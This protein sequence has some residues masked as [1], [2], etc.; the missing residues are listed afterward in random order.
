MMN[1]DG[2]GIGRVVVGDVLGLLICWKRRKEKKHAGDIG[3]CH[4]RVPSRFR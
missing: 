2:G 4:A 1:G 3:P